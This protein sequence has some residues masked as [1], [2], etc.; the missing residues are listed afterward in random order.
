MAGVGVYI[1][2]VNEFYPVKD[3]LFWR[4]LVL[5]GWCALLHGGC[6]CIGHLILTRMLKLGDL[7]VLEKLLAS[8]ALG[9]VAFTMAMYVAGA[10]GIYRPLFAIALPL[11][12]IG[13]GG[14][15]FWRFARQC[16]QKAA[17]VPGER[18]HPLAA[19]AICG[20]VLCL[21]LLYLQCMTPE[22]LNYDSRWYHLT[23]AQD[24]AREG[25]IVRFPADY[26]K[27]FPQLASLIHTWGW[28][29][30][31]L[32]QPLRWML[33]LHNEFFFFVWTLAGVGAVIA[34]LVERDRVP[35]SWAAFF[36]FPTIFVYDSNIG[37]SA[38]HFLAFFTPPLFLAAVRAAEDL[39]PRRCALVGAIAAGAVLTKY[40][41][42]YMLLPTGALLGWRWLWLTLRSRRS[43]SGRG[44][45]WRGPL[46]LLAVGAILT[47]PHFL[48][49]WIFYR[50]PMFPFMTAVFRGTVPH[51]PD[52]TFLVTNMFTGDPNI[53]RGS[54]LT[55]LRATVDNAW[56]FFSRPP[57]SLGLLFPLVLPLV[58]FV[59]GGRRLGMG[60]LIGLAAFL[61]W[62][63]TYPIERY[64]QAILPVF[65]AVAGAVVIRAWQLGWL[66][67]A[68]ILALVGTQIVWGGDALFYS[69]YGRLADS[70]AMIRSGHERRARTRFD[71]YLAPEVAIGKQLPANAVVLFHNSRESLG[72]NRKVLQDLPGF[73][74][75]ISYH[76]VKTARELC[77]LY[78][79][80]GITHMVH[81]RGLWPAFSKQEEVV[82][83]AF[84]GR[85]AGNIF[86]EGGY[87]IV[88]LPPELPPV[89][90]PYRVLSLGIPGYPDGVYPVEAMNVYDPLAPRLKHYPVPAVPVANWLAAPK[91]PESIDGVD[92][93]LVNNE[94]GLPTGLETA[95]REK[96]QYVLAYASNAHFSVHVRKAPASR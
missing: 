88:E 53:P 57:Y 25:R 29:V 85:Y 45:L 59:R 55:M 52:S 38:D 10:L 47:L 36:L 72:V 70:I 4:L 28:L 21:G 60:A 61:L 42:L 63:F 46:T 73:Q 11:T 54:L 17:A 95:L 1:A 44:P 89:E 22:A 48:K 56:L 14:P 93:V 78:R 64:L 69:G 30:P 9:A 81:E 8:M 75:L 31:G 80:F 58:L 2:A 18:L 39:S 90:A 43:D 62:A 41:S 86:R 66:A 49:N 87:E 7:P 12:M 50:N 23:V 91:A 19:A 24:Y 5:W 37:G 16:R 84:L 33:A 35:G 34:W 82:I 65:A 32:N 96:F 74:S 26:N 6:L 76:D 40:Q 27:A 51:Q 13:V 92:V 67:R 77:Q 68:G 79:S 71:Q 94:R 15:A 3:W 20:G 83:A